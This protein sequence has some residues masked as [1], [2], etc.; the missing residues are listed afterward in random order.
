M[1]KYIHLWKDY[2]EQMPLQM[3]SS[4]LSTVNVHSALPIVYASGNDGQ[5]IDREWMEK[6]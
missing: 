1:Y 6:I 4:E 5:R 3:L 2:L